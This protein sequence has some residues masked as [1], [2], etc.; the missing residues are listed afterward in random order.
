MLPYFLTFSYFFTLLFSNFPPRYQVFE[1]Q[2]Q[3]VLAL[4]HIF[5]LVIVEAG[6]DIQSVRGI[7]DEKMQA[8]PSVL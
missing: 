7:L 3:A 5:P 4:S 8:F 2:S 6:G 1:V